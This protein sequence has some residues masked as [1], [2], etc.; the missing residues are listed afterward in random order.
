MY[1]NIDIYNKFV[2]NNHLKRKLKTKKPNPNI[3]DF[4]TRT[5]HAIR[6]NS[7]GQQLNVWLTQKEKIFKRNKQLSCLYIFVK[8][9]CKKN[10]GLIFNKDWTKD[11]TDYRSTIQKIRNIDSTINTHISLYKLNKQNYIKQLNT[12]ISSRIQDNVQINLKQK[13]NSMI[14]SFFLFKKK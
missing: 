11:A 4:S 7:N 14:L 3:Q 9:I 12:L 8:D 5:F 6:G 1:N 10:P 13:F 2:S